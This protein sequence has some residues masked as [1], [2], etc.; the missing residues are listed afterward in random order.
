MITAAKLQALMARPTRLWLATALLL[1]GATIAEARDGDFFSRFFSTDEP[2]AA[3]PE[4]AQPAEVPQARPAA[5]PLTVR[6]RVRPAM[7]KA[8]TGKI[9]PVSI[10]EDRTLRRGDAVMTAAGLRIFKGSSSWP[11][12]PNDFVALSDAGPL[13]PQTQKVLAEIDRLPRR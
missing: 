13:D 12:R 8:A 4:I 5:R 3:E 10:Y 6:K 2:A 11:Y 9:G 7:A 1:S